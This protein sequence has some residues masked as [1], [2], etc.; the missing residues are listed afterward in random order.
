[1]AATLLAVIVALAIQ[2][3]ALARV[4]LGRK[5]GWKGRAYAAPETP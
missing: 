3:T 1:M 2:W 4:L 5:E